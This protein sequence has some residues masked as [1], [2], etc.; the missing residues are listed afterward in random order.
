MVAN[1]PTKIILIFG[2]YCLS[3]VRLLGNF[4]AAFTP[5]VRI[6]LARI[7]AV[8]T[9]GCRKTTDYEHITAKKN[10]N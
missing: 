8:H 1:M 3:L 4:L 9:I 6:L 10:N 5:P 2:V 7:G